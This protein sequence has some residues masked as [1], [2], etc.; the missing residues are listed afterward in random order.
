RMGLAELC[1]AQHE[2]YQKSDVL[3][4]QSA[5]FADLPE[6]AMTP[7]MAHAALVGNR[8]EQ[9]GL[10]DLEGRILARMVVPYPPGIPLIFPGERVTLPAIIAYLRFAE[11]WD[12]QFPGFETDIHGAC[13]APDGTYRLDCVVLPQ[14]QT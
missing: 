5:M 14:A 4:L 7:Q 8:I 10:D 9:V 13:K 2:A 12:Q 6:P 1:A 3:A 11:S